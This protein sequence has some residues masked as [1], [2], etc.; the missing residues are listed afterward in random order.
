MGGKKVKSKAS[1]ELKKLLN[2]D[3]FEEI[4]RFILEKEIPKDLIYILNREEALKIYYA[5]QGHRWE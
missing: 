2:E 4:R 1:K 3:N 5:M